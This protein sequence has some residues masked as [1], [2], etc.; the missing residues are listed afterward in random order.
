MEAWSN[1]NNF[2]KAAN[3]FMQGHLLW[4]NFKT[5]PSFERMFSIY[6]HLFATDLEHWSFL[7]AFTL[8]TYIFYDLNVGA[9]HVISKK[10]QRESK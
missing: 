6:S 7:V 5:E 1:I 10:C 2:H 9:V 8:H 3:E 4:Y